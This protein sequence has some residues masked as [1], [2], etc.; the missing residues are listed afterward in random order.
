ML[1]LERLHSHHIPFGEP[2][3]Q[4]GLIN[5]SPDAPTQ[6]RRHRPITIEVVVLT[7]RSGSF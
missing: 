4:T 1:L 5:S 3:E 6:L 7:T 2:P